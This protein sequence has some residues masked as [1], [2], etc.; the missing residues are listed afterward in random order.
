MSL[1]RR[2][3]TILFQNGITDVTKV[4]KFLG[5][6]DNFYEIIIG[7]ELKK[8]RIPGHE[9]KEIQVKEEVKEIFTVFEKEEEKEQ[10]KI[11]QKYEADLDTFID[12]VEE[13]KKE[14]QVFEQ[15]SFEEE[16][17]DAEEESKKLEQLFT[18]TVTKT[19]KV[20]KPKKPKKLDDDIDDFINTI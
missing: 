2:I 9:Y 16:L 6:K 13:P 4:E 11:E 5:E 18:K 10:E 17:L 15:K 19:I 20:I 12:I 14:K 8:L 7:G 1:D 3:V